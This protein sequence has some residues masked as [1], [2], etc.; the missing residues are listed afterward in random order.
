M[1]ISACSSI[2]CLLSFKRKTISEKHT[3]EKETTST[4]DAVNETGH[5]CVEE[6]TVESKEAAKGHLKSSGDMGLLSI[7]ANDDRY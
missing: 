7:G 3:A 6:K 2:I 1:F 5:E 4:Q